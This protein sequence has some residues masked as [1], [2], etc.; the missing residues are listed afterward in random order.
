VN[1]WSDQTWGVSRR[2]C[3][4]FLLCFCACSVMQSCP[5]LCDPTDCSPPGSSVHGVFQARIL[6]GVATPSSRGSSRPRDRTRVSRVSWDSSTL[7]PPKMLHNCRCS[8]Q[9]STLHTRDSFIYFSAAS[10]SLLISPIYFFPPLWQPPVCSLN[11]CF[12]CVMFVHSLCSFCFFRF[13]L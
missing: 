3:R 5:T 10:L 11:L 7:V 1:K 12:C 13:H 9:H 2:R 8:S 6:E 4:G